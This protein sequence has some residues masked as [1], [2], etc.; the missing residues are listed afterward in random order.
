MVH[1]HHRSLLDADSDTSLLQRGHVHVIRR[2]WL[3]FDT[4]PAVDCVLRLLHIT[5]VDTHAHRLQE[6]SD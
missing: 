4:I 2:F 3:E 5:G 6:A 1:A